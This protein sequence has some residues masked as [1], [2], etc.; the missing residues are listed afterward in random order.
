[1][2]YAATLTPT[3]V[4]E[5]LDQVSN[6][7]GTE[8]GA[9]PVTVTGFLTPPNGGTGNGGNG[10]EV[11]PGEGN[12]QSTLTEA[13]KKTEEERKAAAKKKRNRNLLIGGGILLLIIVLVIVLTTGGKKAASK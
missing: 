3:Q 1:M 5:V 2:A 13:E 6:G 11:P 10:A 4:V 12:G 7:N 9:P 8:E